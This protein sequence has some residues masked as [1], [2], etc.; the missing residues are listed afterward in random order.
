MDFAAKI[1]AARAA[2]KWSQEELAD[3]AGLSTQAVRDIEGEKSSPTIRTQRKILRVFEARNYFFTEHGIE[4][5]EEKILTFDNFLDVLEDAEQVL[6]K[7]EE[8]LLHC[9]DERRNTE[10]VSDKFSELRQEGISLRF[11]LEEGN[12]VITG[13]PEDYRWI[14]P[15]Y[16]AHREVRV[17]YAD[18][19]VIH[20]VEKNRDVFV[21]TKNKDAADT[22]RQEFE[23]FFKRGKPVATQ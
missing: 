13:A 11:T 9:A 6:S 15:E 3:L 1:R 4:F 22:H 7:G 16:F 19:Y 18:R 8:I 5:R 2:I 21:V 23:Y 10:E 20:F 17:I 12:T 14:D